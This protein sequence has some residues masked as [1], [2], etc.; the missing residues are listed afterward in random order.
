MF[1]WATST[2]ESLA[3]TVAPPPTDPYSRIYLACQKR[4]ENTIMD[5]VISQ[6]QQGMIHPTHTI[7]HESKGYTLLHLACLYSLSRLLQYCLDQLQ[8]EA[9]NQPSY[10]I[11]VTD[12]EG[13]TPLHCAAISNQGEA[14]EIIKRLLAIE[15]SSNNN[16]G[17]IPSPIIT[18]QNMS[19]KTPYDVATVNSI[20]QYLL[21]IQLQAETQMAINN[22]GIGLPP[23]IDM[24]GLTIQNAAHLPPPP[25]STAMF[26]SGAGAGIVGGGGSMYAPIPGLNISSSNPPNRPIL[27]HALCHGMISS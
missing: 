2:F 15:A 16:G 3:Q 9:Q 6:A 4:D 1:S 18:V 7:I 25:T 13:N 24:G 27:C 23:G 5:I 11:L 17:H 21:P 8:Q 19:G 14:L 12:K 26:S 10:Y 22:G 20:R